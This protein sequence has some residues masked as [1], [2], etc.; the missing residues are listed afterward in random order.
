MKNRVQLDLRIIFGKNG[1]HLPK[2]TYSKKIRYSREFIFK[3]SFTTSTNKRW[4]GKKPT[5]KNNNYFSSDWNKKMVHWFQK[6]H[7]YLKPK[8]NTTTTNVSI[9]LKAKVSLTIFF[10]NSLTKCEW[11]KKHKLDRIVPTWHDAATACAHARGRALASNSLSRARRSTK[12]RNRKNSFQ[13]LQASMQS[14]CLHC[15]IWSRLITPFFTGSFHLSLFN[16]F[17]H[18]FL[19]NSHEWTR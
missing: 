3:W 8:Y 7:Y 13:S 12:R 15:F 11:M 10:N 17:L 6:L 18:V 5:C 16:G 2:I 9:K 19:Q 4:L 14:P 1:L